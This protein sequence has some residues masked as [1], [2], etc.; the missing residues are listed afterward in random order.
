MAK[1]IY[2]K[3]RRHATRFK[4]RVWK[5]VARAPKRVAR[6]LV[7]RGGEIKYIELTSTGV[8][9]AVVSVGPI[10]TRSNVAGGGGILVGTSATTRIG[11][12]VHA[13]WLLI[14]GY[15]YNDSASTFSN[16][17][18]IGVVRKFGYSS[19]GTNDLVAGDF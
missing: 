19:G 17:I 18:R 14:T 13:R 3:K 15:G 1:R 16:A 10:P 5:A 12:K 6:A 2:K 11:N 8:S 9:T 7:N 4:K